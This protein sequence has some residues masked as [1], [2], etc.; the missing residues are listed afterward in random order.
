MPLLEQVQRKLGAERAMVC[1]VSFK[2]NNEAQLRRW[3]RDLDRHITMLEDDSSDVARKYDVHKIP[4]LFI[5]GRDG[6]ILKVHTGYGPNSIEHLVEGLNAALR[7]R[8]TRLRAHSQRCR[9][10]AASPTQTPVAG[11]C[12]ILRW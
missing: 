1:A 2:E 4:K 12:G 9:S 7:A 11:G 6:T 5:I 10:N 3:A 8:P